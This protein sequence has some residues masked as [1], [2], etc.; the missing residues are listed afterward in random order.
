ME[1]KNLTEPNIQE[2]QAK[3]DKL[4]KQNPDI[5]S[6]TFSCSLPGSDH[7]QLL[8]RINDIENKIDALTRKIDLIFG[9]AV[10]IDGQF[11]IIK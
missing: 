7:Q 4:R 1:I 3:V 11:K 9:G 2:L 5:I 6:R 8:D 10:L